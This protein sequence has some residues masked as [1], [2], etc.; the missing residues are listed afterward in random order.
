MTFRVCVIGKELTI[1][2]LNITILK[3]ESF[4][5]HSD[6]CIITRAHYIKEIECYTFQN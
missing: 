5:Q 6:I 1:V 4:S 3:M 2:V